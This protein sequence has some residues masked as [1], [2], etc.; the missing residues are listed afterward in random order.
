M[1]MLCY[2]STCGHGAG[3]PFMVVVVV[4]GG[5][6]DDRC[7]AGT[8]RQEPSAAGKMLGGPSGLLLV[9]LEEGVFLIVYQRETYTLCTFYTIIGRRAGF[10]FI[11]F[12]KKKLNI[13]YVDVRLTG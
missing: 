9:S 8:E 5:G 11:I 2:V 4:V 6:S 3:K 10:Y 1:H 7:R 13:N 12:F